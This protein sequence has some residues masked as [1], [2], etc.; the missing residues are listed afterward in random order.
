MASLTA[1]IIGAYV[2]TTLHDIS[3]DVDDLLSK[4]SSDS[5][6]A[7]AAADAAA[8]AAAAGAADAAGGESKKPAGPGTVKHL[9]IASG[10]FSVIWGSVSVNGVPTQTAVFQLDTSMLLASPPQLFV[11]TNL[12][13]KGDAESSIVHTQGSPAA[14]VPLY[15]KVAED[16]SQVL[17]Y[18]KQMKIRP[19]TSDDLIMVDDV[20]DTL[21]AELPIVLSN[22]THVTCN[23]LNFIQGHFGLPLEVVTVSSFRFVSVSA[24]PRNVNMVFEV[25]YKKEN[26]FAT[27]QIFFC[28]ALLPETEMVARQV[29]H[30]IGYFSSAYIDVGLHGEAAQSGATT[31][32]PAD[33]DPAIAF[34]NRW[35]LEKA[36]P[37]CSNTEVGCEP[38]KPIIYHVDPTVPEKWQP[39]I[40]QGIELWQP[41]FL[42]LGFKDTPRAILPSDPDWPSDYAAGD[43]RYASVSFAVNTKSVFSVGPSITDPRT[44]EIIDADIGYSQEWVAYFAGEVAQ[45]VLGTTSPTEKAMGSS[46]TDGETSS[47][48]CGEGVEGVLAD[49]HISHRHGCQENR[50]RGL[51]DTLPYAMRTLAD[52]NGKV[53]ISV[54]GDGLADVTVHE[55]GHTLGLRHNFKGSAA[56]LYENI[57]DASKLKVDG[58]TSSVMDYVGPVLP[59]TDDARQSLGNMFFP[60]GYTIGAYDKLAIAYGYTLVQNEDPKQQ[61]PDVAAIADK[62]DSDNYLFGSDYDAFIE[63]DP[64]ARRYDLTSDPV[65][66]SKDQFKVAKRILANCAT[67]KA[68]SH[69]QNDGRAYTYRCHVAA[70]TMQYHAARN[71]M[72]HLGASVI[73]H[74]FNTKPETVRPV[75]SSYQQEAL[76]VVTDFISDPV[77]LDTL[78]LAKMVS[79]EPPMGG[80]PYVLYASKLQDS[81][82]NVITSMGTTLLQPAKLHRIF[83]ANLYLGTSG[84]T[85]EDMWLPKNSKLST[86]YTSVGVFDILNSVVNAF[87]GW[88][89]TPTPAWKQQG[90][91][92]MLKI[93]T[94]ALCKS[95]KEARASGVAYAA[96][97]TRVANAI[98]ANANSKA[99]Q[100]SSCAVGDSSS[101]AEECF[102]ADIKSLLT[103]ALNANT[104]TNTE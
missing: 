22:A 103:A 10:W 8:A 74:T 83:N 63:I 98:I 25:N 79:Y 7:A 5:D 73:A 95:I 100:A 2:S 30:R 47:M 68:V 102:M 46:Q 6:K 41:A 1:L 37:S 87:F 27:A 60:G 14:G 78:T 101:T 96:D 19:A 91:W 16:F 82:I 44:G 29:D 85:S 92:K 43:I 86:T 97:L 42:A 20:S 62:L 93:V 50:L 33:A 51:R 69:G 67:F 89:D 81:F 18:V 17:V 4:Y 75:A 84:I 21:L 94:V 3:T 65:A 15:F 28:F 57:Y 38:A 72:Y 11:L 56:I 9:Q 80:A 99:L 32:S 90:R 61:H 34:I 104:S 59:P 24:F 12:W 23:A 49:M 64:L 39:Y 71:A 13:E 26:F 58:S 45:G 88:N 35:R 53:P 54:V 77:W 31:I 48:Q 66:Y 55:V 76:T 70:L 36:D 40:K 52:A